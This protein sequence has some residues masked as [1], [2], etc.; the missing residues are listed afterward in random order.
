[1]PSCLALPVSIAAAASL[2][3]T[4]AILASA[5][6]TLQ[7]SV[8]VDRAA[9]ARDAGL[10]AKS[11][12][13]F[14]LQRLTT[15]RNAVD[16]YLADL[17]DG[18]FAAAWVHG[19]A[20]AYGVAY[21]RL[22]A[23]GVLLSGPVVVT[24]PAE[25]LSAVALAPG[26]GAV[27]LLWT[28]RL[29]NTN[30]VFFRKLAT[31]GRPLTEKLRIDQADD[32]LENDLTS[33]VAPGPNT[34]GLGNL[35]WDGGGWGATWREFPGLDPAQ[36]AFSR[37]AADGR[38]RIPP[39]VLSDGPAG[40]SA[41]D[42][43][44]VWNGAS[45]S[46][47]WVDDRTGSDQLHLRAVGTD[48]VPLAPSVALT[49]ASALSGQPA[50]GWNGSHLGLTW[51]DGRDEDDALYFRLFS[52]A[53]APASA[54]TRLTDPAGPEFRYSYEPAI[55]WAGDRWAIA[56]TDFRADVMNE[57]IRLSFADE[58]GDKLGADVV[59]STPVDEF[60]SMS[61]ALVATP[62][63]LLV[64]WHDGGVSDSLE[65]HAQA[66][67]VSG[68]PTAARRILTGGHVPGFGVLRFGRTP[69]LIPLPGG[70][71]AVAVLEEDGIFA[72]SR[73]LLTDALGNVTGEIVVPGTPF[74]F[75]TEAHV[76]TSGTVLAV[77]SFGDGRALLSRFDL[78]GVRLG[79]DL[80][81]ST[82]ARGNGALIWDG[83][84]FLAAWVDNRDGNREIYAAAVTA[85]GAVTGGG[86]H[87]ISNNSAFSLRPA[88]AAGDGN[89]L[90]V[91]EDDRG[92]AREL[93]AAVLD[94]AGNR[95]GAELAV[96]ANDGQSS[97]Q[98]AL[99]WGGTR[100]GLAWRELPP[101]A[102]TA[103]EFV[104]LTPAGAADGAAVEIS[105]CGG[106]A[107]VAAAA[108]RWGVA[109]NGCGGLFLAEVASDG[110]L[111]T[112][113]RQ[114]FRSPA[115]G[116][117][118]DLAWDGA[119]FVLA[120]AAGLYPVEELYLT[121]AP[122]ATDDSPPSCPAGLTATVVGVDVDLAW[123][124]GADGDGGVRWQYLFRNGRRIASLLPGVGRHRDTD[125]PNGTHEYQVVTVNQGTRDA[126]GCATV[127]VQVDDLI[128]ADDFESGDTS[129]WGPAGP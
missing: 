94:G 123:A 126:A 110:S 26:G 89:R 124:P 45:H 60:L 57:E 27:G 90:V 62:S 63:G 100:F 12:P 39:V 61:P 77:L 56:A 41:F 11:G 64:A 54:E 22:D 44:L 46:V 40:A 70:G 48:G 97:D 19:V 4:P 59:V 47:I 67:D 49:I 13:G 15:H 16:P 109:F 69:Q 105:T 116:R 31:N 17:G 38:S 6:P 30:G 92:T 102:F 29:G 108:N 112:P 72:E 5:V 32:P 104:R 55:A 113:E 18:T 75:A 53:G 58:D 28:E 73:L 119:R 101:D 115:F 117:A 20:Q 76:A 21:A 79:S 7:R 121:T 125:L 23:S 3:L 114:V 2:L 103:T 96:T 91:W 83:S 86:P 65:I 68:S 36:V 129:A 98:P 24:P 66:L 87:R 82:S 107:S 51:I 88:L 1:M 111:L 43:R 99:A 127:Q 84:V 33:G 8:A 120:V 128:F 78:G 52:T 10:A 106:F 50:L 81:L 34:S 80:E 25:E 9:A 74:H 37:I 35:A 71:H 93:W 42:P 122:C 95:V 14:C 118:G 85:D